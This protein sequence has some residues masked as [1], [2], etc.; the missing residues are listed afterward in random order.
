MSLAPNS[1]D[2]LRPRVLVHSLALNL[3]VSRAAN[4]G[5]DSAS[6]IRG[7]GCMLIRPPGGWSLRE[8]SWSRA[9]E[10]LQGRSVSSS[11]GARLTSRVRPKPW[12]TRRSEWPY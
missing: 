11:E 2:R 12:S 4:C 1:P 5:S 10:S 3:R 8:K 7:T 9:S 6:A